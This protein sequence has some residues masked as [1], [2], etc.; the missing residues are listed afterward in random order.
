MLC[1]SSDSRLH[2]TV[3]VTCMSLAA[4]WKLIQLTF[5]VGRSWGLEGTDAHINYRHCTYLPASGR[6]TSIRA[7]VVSSNTLIYANPM[8][9]AAAES[10]RRHERSCLSLR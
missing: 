7:T 4:T 8:I 6:H 10:R 1:C 5:H 3:A 2:C 9:K